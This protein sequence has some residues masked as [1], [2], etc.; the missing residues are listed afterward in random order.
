MTKVLK[1]DNSNIIQDAGP[2]TM[3]KRMRLLELS[4]DDIAEGMA[5]A[6]TP[7]C[8]ITTLDELMEWIH[9]HQVNYFQLQ[10]GRRYTRINRYE[11]GYGHNWYL[12]Y[13]DSIQLF[14]IKD[15]W[16]RYNVRMVN[17]VWGFTQIP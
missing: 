9:H 3:G 2:T 17:I 7:T 1:R 12:E 14:D 4:S 6:S 8:V 13:D 5:P 10:R 15:F 11:S 16:D